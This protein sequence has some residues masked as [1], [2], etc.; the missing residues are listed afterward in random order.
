MEAL[1]RYLGGLSQATAKKVVEEEPGNAG[2]L[3]LRVAHPAPQAPGRCMT[4]K[5]GYFEYSGTAGQEQLPHVLNRECGLA[6]DPRLAGSGSFL[7]LELQH[8]ED[9]LVPMVGRHDHQ[10]ATRWLVL[11]A[12]RGGACGRSGACA[13]TCGNVRAVGRRRDV[14]VRGG[15]VTL[16]GALSCCSGPS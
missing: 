13:G 1:R 11:N 2:A 6:F 12:G 16:L 7:L 10:Q 4:A 3:D 15:L 5:G 9:R 8:D 14:S